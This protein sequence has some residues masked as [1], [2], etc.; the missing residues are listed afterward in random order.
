MFRGSDFGLI[1]E[2]AAGDLAGYCSPRGIR[3]S[4]KER[5]EVREGESGEE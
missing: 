5:D 2:Y 3:L 4:V 1:A